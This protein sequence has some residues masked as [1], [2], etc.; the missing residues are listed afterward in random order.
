MTLAVALFIGRQIG[1][2]PQGFLAAA[3]DSGLR[4]LASLAVG[5]C[6]GIAIGFWDK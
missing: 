3:G 2:V 4:A 6:L 1:L 5:G